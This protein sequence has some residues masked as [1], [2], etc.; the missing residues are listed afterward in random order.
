MPNTVWFA[1]IKKRER[2]RHRDRDRERQRTKDKNSGENCNKG[3]HR[4][5]VA[6]KMSEE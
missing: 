1:K 6:S 2:E 4:E 3:M 5:K